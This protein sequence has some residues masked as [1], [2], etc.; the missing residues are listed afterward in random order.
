MKKAVAIMG[1]LEAKYS[2]AFGVA[3][4]ARPVGAKGQPERAARLLG[5]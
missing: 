3:A 4:M 2:I 5:A 1:E